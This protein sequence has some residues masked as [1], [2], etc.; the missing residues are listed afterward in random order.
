MPRLGECEQ[1][2]LVSNIQNG[3]FL[4]GSSEKNATQQGTSPLTRDSQASHLLWLWAREGLALD[5]GR[6][7]TSQTNN[8][9]SKGNPPKS[10]RSHWFG[11]ALKTDSFR[12]RDSMVSQALIQVNLVDFHG[13]S[14]SRRSST[15]VRPQVGGHSGAEPIAAPLRQLPLTD[16]PKL[17]ST[18][19]VK[20]IC[21]GQRRIY[22]SALLLHSFVVLQLVS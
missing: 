9:E 10:V 6:I 22:S 13:S 17:A 14:V 3:R 15:K 8:P 5:S 19:R 18:E 21:F 12:R 7:R 11:M 20:Q 2:G 16:V 1:G 4:F